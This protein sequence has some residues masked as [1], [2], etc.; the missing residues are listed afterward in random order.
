MVRHKNGNEPQGKM[1]SVQQ[2]MS[3]VPMRTL[4]QSALMAIRGGSDGTASSGDPSTEPPPVIR[5]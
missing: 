2:G 5:G 4:S 3:R 1:V